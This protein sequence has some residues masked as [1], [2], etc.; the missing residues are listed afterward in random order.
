[1]A[2]SWIAGDS[3]PLNV[4]DANPRDIHPTPG[5]CRLV[6][7]FRRRISSAVYRVA[8]VDGRGD[9]ATDGRVD[10]DKNSVLRGALPISLRA[11]LV[12]MFLGRDWW[13]SDQCLQGIF[14][15]FFAPQTRP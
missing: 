12:W 3:R 4:C 2:R 14:D 11:S 9:E 15:S 8:G 13:R 7:G 1:M 10:L 6:E 5:C